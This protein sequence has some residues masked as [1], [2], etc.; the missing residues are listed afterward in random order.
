MAC[1]CVHKIF[2]VKVKHV[3][4]TDYSGI[5]TVRTDKQC[6]AFECFLIVRPK[7]YLTLSLLYA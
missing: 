5:I 2:Y 1:T 6:I 3:F 7:F 4:L